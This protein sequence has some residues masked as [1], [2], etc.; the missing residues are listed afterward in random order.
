M[1]KLL[2]YNGRLVRY[3]DLGHAPRIPTR[4]FGSPPCLRKIFPALAGEIP[5]SEGRELLKNAAFS[6]SS[7]QPIDPPG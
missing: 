6:H 3:G 1:A 4:P 7:A 5:C 2:F